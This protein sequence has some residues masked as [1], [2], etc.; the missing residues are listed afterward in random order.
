[1]QMKAWDDLGI[2]TKPHFAI[3]YPGS[4]W[5]TEYRDEILNQYNGTRKTRG[6]TMI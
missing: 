1:M 3:A 4:L 5:F 2:V 6:Y